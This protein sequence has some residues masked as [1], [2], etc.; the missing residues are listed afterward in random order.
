MGVSERPFYITRGPDKIP[1]ILWTPE[2][3]AGPVPLVLMGHGGQSEKRNPAGL[4]MAR[5]FVRR[6][7]IAVGAIDHGERGPIV[8]V[9]GGHPAYL[10]LWK[11]PDTIDRSNAGWVATLDALLATG[12]FDPGRVGYWGLSM[13]T[14]LGLP[15]VACDPRIKAA[16]LGACGF[17][18]PSAIRGHIGERHRRDAKNVTCPVMF[19][20]QWDDEVF[21]RDGVFEMF[22]LLGSADKQM[23]VHPGAHGAVP[24]EA[25]DASREFLA[26]RL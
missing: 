16:V 21:H 8:D 1:G 7:S 19:L 6:N 25:A 11:R 22:G 13:G 23:R 14:M 20:A 5:R 18:G 24:L 3:P 4:A 26:A 15:F 2:Q 12:M 10:D 9:A 17:T